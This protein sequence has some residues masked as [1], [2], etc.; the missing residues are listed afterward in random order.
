MKPTKVP[1]RVILTLTLL[2]IALT[3]NAQT[4]QNQQAAL[5]D[6]PIL[7]LDKLLQAPPGSSTD[8]TKLK[9][10]LVVLEFW[11]TWCSPCVEQI[12]HLN[13][14]ARELA[15]QTACRYKS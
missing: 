8:W 4:N 12:P 1:F 14:M 6:A 5:R 11:A 7:K 15:D 9:G 3:A 13:E 2:T 10:K